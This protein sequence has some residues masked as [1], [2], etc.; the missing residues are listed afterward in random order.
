MLKH[1]RNF[2][3]ISQIFRSYLDIW[4]CSSCIH[5]SPFN[6]NNLSQYIFLVLQKCHTSNLTLRLPLFVELHFFLQILK[7]TGLENFLRIMSSKNSIQN[8][9]RLALQWT[10]FFRGAFCTFSCVRSEAAN[11][12]KNFCWVF[13]IVTC[14]LIILYSLLEMNGRFFLSS[15]QNLKDVILS[16]VADMHGASARD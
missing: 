9:Q 14:L 3:S 4:I 10:K 2:F 11:L 7:N 5:R 8:L 13:M 6:N 15:W 12:L 16:S 1:L